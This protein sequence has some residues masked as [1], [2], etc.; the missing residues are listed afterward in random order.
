MNPS[1]SE[2]SDEF[3]AS[4]FKMVTRKETEVA[5]DPAQEF[6]TP[7]PH[8]NVEGT[9]VEVTFWYYNIDENSLEPGHAMTTKEKII[10]EVDGRDDIEVIQ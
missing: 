1:P 2:W 9:S 3:L 5:D 7:K 8:V 10:D 6:T 4:V